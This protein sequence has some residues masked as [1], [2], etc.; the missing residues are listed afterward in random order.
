MLLCQLPNHTRIFEKKS[1][2]HFQ[3]KRLAEIRNKLEANRIEAL[4]PSFS[5]GFCSRLFYAN[6]AVFT[7]FDT[8]GGGF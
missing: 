7:F 8:C 2:Q 3:T 5:G 4:M 6:I 1:C